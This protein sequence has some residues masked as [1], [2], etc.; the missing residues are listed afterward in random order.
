MMKNADVV[1]KRL[2][3]AGCRHA[4]GIP[5]GEVLTIM[6]ALE[7]AGVAFHLVKH[8]NNGGFMAEGTHHATAAPGVLVATIGPGVVNAINTVTNAWQ[9]QVPLIFLT[10]CID[11]PD[12]QYFTHRAFNQSKLVTSITK[13]SFTL[14]EGAID[15][16]IDKAI[17][18]AVDSRPGPVHIDIPISLAK[19]SF[20]GTSMIPSVRS[21]A[22]APAIGPKL[23]GARKIIKGAKRPLMIAG[24]DVLHHQAHEVVTEAVRQFKIPLITTYKTKGILPEDHPLSMGGHGLSP[25]SFYIIKPLIEAADVII[26]VGYDP[27]EMRAEWISPWELGDNGPMVIDLTATPN[28][29][30][31]HQATLSF[32]GNVGASLRAI[33]QDVEPNKNVWPE[34]EPKEIRNQLTHAFPSDEEWGPAAI[35]DV[36]QTV[37]PKTG[38]ITVDTGAHRIL[39]NQQWQCFGP[40]QILQSSALCTM[41][42]ALPLAIGYKVARPEVPVLAFTGDAGLEMVLG[43]LASARD[44]NLTIPVIVFV[45]TQLALIELKQR[46][47][48]LPNL[49]VDFGYTDFAAVAEALGGSGITVTNRTDL[50]SAIETALD[51]DTF[52]LIACPIEKRSYDNRL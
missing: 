2:Y 40:R 20:N 8:E 18:I 14:A 12:T 37:F 7:E 4:F 51:G 1:A 43:E 22:M 50:A 11:Y 35:I 52:T 23:D 28:T 34:Q 44:M 25:K 48:Q 29:H 21:E 24:I 33:T 42:V 9:D 17:A 10:G 16:I 49:G 13:A 31:M 19:S 45:D 3:K 36:A 15:I 41:G 26:L 39:L 5:G 32:V 46:H 47:D 38:V 30:Y 6:A 27:I